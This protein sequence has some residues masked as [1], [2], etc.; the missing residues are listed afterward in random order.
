[1][2]PAGLQRGNAAQWR[3][4][5]ITCAADRKSKG[6]LRVADAP[7]L[8]AQ[9]V[10]KLEPGEFPLQWCHL[11]LSAS[12]RILPPSSADAARLLGIGSGS[13]MFVWHR[14]SWITQ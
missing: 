3:V 11:G 8:G 13:P 4:E 1:M 2:R 9:P 6:L 12:S 14:W 10:E 5:E 7:E